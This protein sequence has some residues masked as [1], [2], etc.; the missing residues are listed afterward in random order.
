MQALGLF[1]PQKCLSAGRR[2]ATS[3]SRL[4]YYRKIDL[5]P[6]RIKKNLDEMLFQLNFTEFA[7][8]FQPDLTLPESTEMYRSKWALKTMVAVW[9][10]VTV[11]GVFLQQILSNF[12]NQCSNEHPE[13]FM[14][15]AT[16]VVSNGLFQ[17]KNPSGFKSPRLCA[18][19]KTDILDVQ[20]VFSFCHWFEGHPFVLFC[21]SF[22]FVCCYKTQKSNMISVPWHRVRKLP[23]SQVLWCL[24]PRT[25]PN[26]E[27]VA[28]RPQASVYS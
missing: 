6:Q 27:C 10:N 12:H 22:C 28:P 18:N 13:F 25:L 1:F 15:G 3:R 16:C 26:P 24:R 23:G 11:I 14:N 7:R 2:F 8:S 20:F 21:L 17:I 19:V 9:P 5:F 4:D